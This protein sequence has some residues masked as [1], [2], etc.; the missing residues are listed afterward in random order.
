EGLF[1]DSG[2]AKTVLLCEGPFDALALDYSIGP[3]NRPKYVI[4]A[5]PGTFKEEWAQYFRGR[6]ARLFFDNDDAGRK[7]TEKVAKLLLDGGAAEVKALRWP[8]AGP[9]PD[10]TPDGVKDLNDLVG[11]FGYTQAPDGIK[12][13]SVLGWLIKNC[14]EAVHDSQLDWR[15]GWERK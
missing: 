13:R 3:Q 1:K 7:L 14:Y 10:G 2:K 4:V 6:K 11:S 12:P 9:L 8:E 5:V 15:F